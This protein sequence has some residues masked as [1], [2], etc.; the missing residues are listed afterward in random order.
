M[1]IDSIEFKL[2]LKIEN[3]IFPQSECF[4]THFL[5]TF[6][7]VIKKLCMEVCA[8]Q[9]CFPLSNRKILIGDVNLNDLT[10]LNFGIFI[11]SHLKKKF[12]NFFFCIIQNDTFLYHSK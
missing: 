6:Y 2:Q 5:H 3:L 8:Q 9:T 10:K 11:L 4:F 1:S 7:T 12:S